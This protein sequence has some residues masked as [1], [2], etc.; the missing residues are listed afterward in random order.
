MFILPY[1]MLAATGGMLL[2]VMLSLKYP[3]QLAKLKGYVFGNMVDAAWNQYMQT[4]HFSK[5]GMH[6]YRK[7]KEELGDEPAKRKVLE[8]FIQSARDRNAPD[9]AIEIVKALHGRLA[10]HKWLES[11]G[12]N[13]LQS[14]L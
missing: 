14:N 11:H 7:W 2:G 8:D 6:N 9:E 13:Q 5:K 3:E 1:I 10:A 4:H 12:P